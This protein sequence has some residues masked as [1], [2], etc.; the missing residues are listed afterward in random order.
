M[1]SVARHRLRIASSCLLLVALVS[2][3]AVAGAAQCEMPSGCPMM[4]AGSS[5]PLCHGASMTTTDCCSMERLPAVPERTVEAVSVA[6]VSIH[7]AGTVASAAT[8]N[9]LRCEIGANRPPSHPPLH[10]Y[11]LFTTLLI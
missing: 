1:R 5:A 11:T 7:Q 4:G 2:P 9:D 8:A 10:L 6:S 3:V